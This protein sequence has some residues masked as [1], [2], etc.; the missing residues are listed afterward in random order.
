MLAPRRTALP[1]ALAVASLVALPLLVYGGP[2]LFGHV[3]APGDDLTQSLPLRQLVGRDLSAGHL[4]IFDPYLW[5]GAPLLAGWNAGAAYPLTWL[6]AVLPAAAAWT[7]TLASA[8]VAA[9]VGCYA[10]LRANGLRVVAGWMGAVTFAFGGGMSAQLSHVGLVVGMAW[11]PLG[12]LAILRL[13]D[14]AASGGRVLARCA[15]WTALLAASA[16]L[17]VLAGEP[18]AI[19]D[20]AAVLLLYGSWRLGRLALAARRGERTPSAVAWGVAGVL[21]G[22]VLGLGLGAVQL[23]PGLAAV[24]T[25]QRAVVT[26][27][28][29]SAGSMPAPWLLLLGVPDLLGGSGAFGQPAFFASY[30]LTEVTGYVGMLPLA[31]AGALLGRLRHRGPLPEWAIWY[32]VAAAGVLLA[33]GANTPLWHL[34]IRIPLFGG[35]RLQSRSI[36]VTGLALAVLLAYWAD[37]WLS[38]AGAAARRERLLGTLLPAGVVAIVVVALAWRVPLLEWMGV[39]RPVAARASAIGPWLVPFL[40]LAVAATGLVWWGGHPGWRGRE[41]RAGTGGT[42]RAIALVAF[43]VLD[44]VVFAVTTV[45]AVGT[46]AAPVPAVALGLPARGSA[47]GRATA[48]ATD[49]RATAEATGRRATADVTAEATADELG[50]RVP[51]PDGVRPVATLRLGG[52]FAVYDPT[53]RYPAQLSALDAPDV[54]VVSG[55][56]SVE[57]YGSIV[58]GRYA[59]TTGTHGVS[60]TGQDVFSPQAA[61]DGVLDALDTVAVLVPG[62]YLVSAVQRGRTPAGRHDGRTA[63]PDRPAAWELGTPLAVASVT[64]RLQPGV[65]DPDDARSGTDEGRSGGPAVPPVPAG[66]RVGLVRA[67]GRVVWSSGVSVAPSTARG[68]TGWLATW[69][70]PVDA[71]TVEVA[72]SS[73]EALEAPVVTTGGG[74]RLRP[75]GALDAALL[76]PHWTYAGRDGAFAMFRNHRARKPL[77][78]QALPGGTLEGA[79]VAGARGPALDPVSARV[80]SPHGVSVVRAV[81][82]IPGW[83]ATW[84]PAG[85]GRPAGPVPLAVRRDGVVQEVRVPAGRGTLTWRYRAPGLEAGAA[86]S[87]GALVVVVALA[88]VAGVAGVAADG[89]GTVD[90]RRR[91]RGSRATRAPTAAP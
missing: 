2:A 40:V 65:S 56:S 79:S 29:F 8:V 82:A 10:F 28:L 20:A 9:G 91:R 70:A 75:S 16:G 87:A 39:S 24:A 53:L 73:A 85:P 15:G 68:S 26:S 50:R 36:L 32:V 18:R 63:G 12:M 88:G 41:P 27:Y 86:L 46:S 34:L 19:A 11:V 77:T 54:N 42:A 60:G 17:V 1:A 30:N 55:T 5:S 61:A 71:V 59:R 37:G 48:E 44:L 51:A 58:D 76:P 22:G 35:Q 45:V 52:R 6:F 64:V 62:D 43:V 31:A 66:V 3:V 67:D 74:A 25:S 83:T 38:G 69:R 89:V 81:A 78:L 21:A 80:S 33:L 84:T 90:G 49:R 4:P 14:R 72:T 47:G 57:G 7:V 23:L 13:T